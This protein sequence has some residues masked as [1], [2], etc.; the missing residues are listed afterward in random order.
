M[1]QKQPKIAVTEPETQRQLTIFSFLWP[2]MAGVAAVKSNV[3][4]QPSNPGRRKR[5]P[6]GP[7]GIQAPDRREVR[8]EF[9]ITSLDGKVAQV[10]PFEEWERIDQKLAG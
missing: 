2:A 5:A 6:Q 7:R 9:Y 1:K 3:S 4:R 8:S 10:Y